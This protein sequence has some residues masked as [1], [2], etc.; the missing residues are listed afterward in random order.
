MNMLSVVIWQQL[1]M[2]DQWIVP[3]VRVNVDAKTQL[4]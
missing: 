3:S 4:Y 1:N 2:T